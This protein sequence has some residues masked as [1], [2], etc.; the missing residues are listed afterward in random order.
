MNISITRFLL[1][2]LSLAIVSCSSA[3]DDLDPTKNWSA[4]KIYTEAKAQMLD[5]NYEQAAKLYESLQTRY[6][7]GIYSQQAELEQ[8]YSYYKQGE[9]ASAISEADRFI[10]AHPS[11]PGVDYAYYM[12]GLANF[13]DDLGLFG[14]YS[15]SDLAQRDSKPY[16]DAFETF[17][18]LVTR[19][20][21]SKYTPDAVVRMRY[22]VN[23]LAKGDVITARYYYK[24]QAYLAA[25]DRAKEVLSQYPKSP[26]V[27]EAIYIMAK[28]YQAMHLTKLSEDA[29]RVLNRDFPN[30]RFLK[31][32]P[33][34]NTP[35][36][37]KIL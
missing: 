18:E 10:K 33:S 26:Q 19:F 7:Y 37:K 31:N 32:K 20:P 24:R 8:I 13:D 23:A 17:K 28:S 29:F 16:R 1:L 3:T 15:Q 30:S 2:T 22:I 35:W 5:G 12:K 6:P 9:K 25:V 4:S 21:K 36:W 14:V 27:E 11:H 34:I